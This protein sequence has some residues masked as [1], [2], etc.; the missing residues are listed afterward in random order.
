MTYRIMHSIWGLPSPGIKTVPL[1]SPAL[2]S[3]GGFFIT[4][5]TW[6]V[7]ELPCPPPGDLANP[8]IEPRSHALQVDSLP[9]EPPR[10]PYC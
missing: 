10:S 7:P 8:G 4:S 2:A 1:V 6:E 9:S 3:A 5:A